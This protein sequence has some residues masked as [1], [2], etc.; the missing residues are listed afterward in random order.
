[1]MKVPTEIRQMWTDAYNLLVD[2]YKN[3]EALNG[4]ADDFFGNLLERMQNESVAHHEHPHIND[5]LLAVYDQAARL[6]KEK[7]NATA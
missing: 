3:E 4:T 1:M 5:L 7:H 6:W 2:V